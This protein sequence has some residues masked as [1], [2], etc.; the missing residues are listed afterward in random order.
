MS[1]FEKWMATF[2]GHYRISYSSKYF[3][4]LALFRFTEITSRMALLSCFGIALGGEYIF[5]MLLFDYFSIIFLGI[6]SSFW[7]KNVW[8]RKKKHLEKEKSTISLSDTRSDTMAKKLK[9][10][11]IIA[12]KNMARNAKRINVLDALSA[13]ACRRQTTMPTTAAPMT[14][15]LETDETEYER[16]T[17]P[18]QCT[19]AP[20]QT[21]MPTSHLR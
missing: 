1:N 3:I 8:K 10:S 14:A 4:I 13:Q 6:I 15:V 5:S 19:D 7:E 17:R 20:P 2:E 16:T 12:I 21:T 9:I 11:N 18:V